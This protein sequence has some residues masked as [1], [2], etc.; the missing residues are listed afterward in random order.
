MNRPPTAEQAAAVASDA[1]EVL[2]RAGAG[3]GKTTVLV[4]RYCDLIV[5]QQ[6][7][8]EQILA[9]T[10]TRKAAAQLRERIRLALLQRAELAPE[11]ET[12]DRLRQAAGRI[13]AAWVMT[14]HSFCQAV[15]AAHPVAAGIDPAFSVIEGVAREQLRH[16]AFAD[17]LDRFLA[18]PT[19]GPARESTV[20][21]YGIENLRQLVLKVHDE[22]RSHGASEPS[23]PE[24]ARGDPAE[25]LDRLAAT[26]SALLAAADYKPDKRNHEKIANLQRIAQQGRGWL[27]DTEQGTGPAALLAELVANRF[28]SK[29]DGKRQVVEL[30]EALCRN[31]H[32]ELDGA[33]CYRHISSLLEL[34]GAQFAAAKAARSGL[35][36][37]D[38]QLL[39]VQLLREHPAI[40]EGYRG[41]FRHIMVDEFQD[42]SPVQ[43]ALIEALKGPE[44]AIFQV[45]DK[46]QAIYA[47]RH[48][49]LANFDQVDR[50]LQA[51]PS[52]EVLPLSGNFRS[53]AAILAVVNGVAGDLLPGFPEL[54]VGSD[55]QSRQPRGGGSG[56]ELMLTA[57]DGWDEAEPAPSAAEGVSL[58]RAAEAE[59]IAH[60]LSQLAAEGVPRGDIVLLLRTLSQAGVYAAALDRAGLRPFVVNGRGFWQGREV[61]DALALLRA[62]ANPLDEEGLFGALAGPACAASPDSL[63][64]LRQAAGRQPVWKAVT[65][66]AVDG[67]GGDGASLDSAEWLDSIAPED[68]GAIASLHADLLHLRAQRAKAGLTDLIE[69]ALERT[70]LD[71]AAAAGSRG[72][73]GLAA[74]RKL[75]RLATEYEAAEGRD[76]RGFLDYAQMQAETG[77]EAEAPTAAEGHD[78]VRIMTMHAA[79]GLEF[80]VVVVPELARRFGGG[81]NTPS[82]RLS[83]RPDGGWLVGLELAR[84]GAETLKLFD[85]EAI[86]ELEKEDQ[87]AEELRLFYVAMTRAKERLILSGQAASKPKNGITHSTPIMPRLLDLLGIEIPEDGPPPNVEKPVFA[88]ARPRQDLEAHFEPVEL[89]LRFNWPE[90]EHRMA[91]FTRDPVLSEQAPDAATQPGDGNA[92]RAIADGQ[93]LRLGDAQPS[94][95]VDAIVAAPTEALP[96]PPPPLPALSFTSLAG[97]AA[98]AAPDQGDEAPG[99]PLRSTSDE[100]GLDAAGRS[101]G[102]AI[103]SLLERALAPAVTG[104]RWRPPTYSMITRALA[105]RGLPDSALL[106]AR[107]QIEGWLASPLCREISRPGVRLRTEAP[108]LLRL[109]REGEITLRGWIDLLAESTDDP[110]LVIDY[111]S[112][113]L[114]GH[115]PED[116]VPV[117]R[118]QAEIYAL[119]VSRA[120]AAPLVEVAFVVLDDPGRPV[121]QRFGPEELAEVEEGLIDRIEDLRMSLQRPPGA[122]NREDATLEGPDSARGSRTASGLGDGTLETSSQLV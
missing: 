73:A 61:V 39:A 77:A 40:G 12:A 41:R 81:P 86:R 43:V 14:I 112:N 94:A 54:R 85:C 27:R 119:A 70:G 76:L 8:P 118:L 66:L 16:S 101:Y 31:L 52:A 117:Y 53:S 20:A 97:Q 25:L 110:P 50:R 49:D 24:P 38:L 35:D 80:P 44:T 91:T 115:Q 120:L 63:W 55:A 9:F 64:L 21:A 7:N 48:A 19:D 93:Q 68:R 99:P 116:L 30:A 109:G 121:R 47:F 92:D 89:E 59:A 108:L 29:A 17:A 104:A 6:L 57:S 67:A 15:I 82:V 98:E 72:R 13:G 3:S 2:L 74:L 51:D 26:T 105:E 107:Q 114:D 5:R 4:D 32:E 75:S 42:T 122:S 60:R 56:V 102:I 88:P 90:P 33:Q 34:Y 69:Q 79:K 71:L 87:A 58:K 28:G 62:V 103:H 37:D 106:R 18:D 22:L 65:A 78:G 96:E 111:K 83:R 36:F 46:F 10:F 95:S 23:L 11:G 113:Q 84:L 1:A 100:L 45:G